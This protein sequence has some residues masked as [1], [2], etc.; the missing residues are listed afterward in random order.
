M[1]RYRV[2]DHTADLAIT[3]FGATLEETF[4][5]AAYAMFDQMADLGAI[6]QFP[7]QRELEL[8]AQ[9]A[10][11]LLREWLG[12]LLFVA[13]TEGL[14]FGRFSVSILSHWTLRGTAWGADISGVP[15]RGSTQVKAVTYH[16]LKIKKTDA[17]YEASVVFDT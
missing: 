13:E 10:E 8:R 15:P 17:G 4:A 11:L 16:G 9:S 3:A 6:A 5:N 1:S 14:I 12:E 7:E 2:E